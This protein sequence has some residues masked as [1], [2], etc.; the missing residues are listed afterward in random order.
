M[1]NEGEENRKLFIILSNVYDGAEENISKFCP[2][3]NC[4][5]NHLN[6]QSREIVNIDTMCEGHFL[7]IYS[8][9]RGYQRI[10][11]LEKVLR[12]TSQLHS[13]SK[14]AKLGVFC[15]KQFTYILTFD[16]YLFKNCYFYNV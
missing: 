7:I 16:A 2:D 12:D 3:R 10:S 14:S 15:N 8:Q 9:S 6:S 5:K 11:N 4:N 13:G 1:H